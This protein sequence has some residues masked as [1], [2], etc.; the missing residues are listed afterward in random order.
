MPTS[1]PVF[2]MRLVSGKE[3]PTRKIDAIRV[4]VTSVPSD[5]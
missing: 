3:I 4:L 5:G 2:G 1:F